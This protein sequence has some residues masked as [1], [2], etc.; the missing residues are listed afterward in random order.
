MWFR[1][2]CSMLHTYLFLPNMYHAQILCISYHAG[3]RCPSVCVWMP[4]ILAWLVG[5]H[6]ADDVSQTWRANA[7]STKTGSTFFSCISFTPHTGSRF[8]LRVWD[9]SM[10]RH[11]VS[12]CDAL[13]KHTSITDGSLLC[14]FIQCVVSVSAVCLFS[15]LSWCWQTLCFVELTCILM[16][17]VISMM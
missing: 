6:L 14:S 16:S 15:F 9:G 10:W 8:G 4:K 13:T 5:F 7:M 3:S 11:F 2:I 12:P 17:V 1:Y